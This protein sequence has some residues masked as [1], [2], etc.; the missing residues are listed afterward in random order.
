MHNDEELIIYSKKIHY[1]LNAIDNKFAILKEIE[2]LDSIATDNDSIPKWS[3]WESSSGDYVYG[4]TKMAS[5]TRN[6]KSNPRNSKL[7]SLIEEA[8]ILKSNHYKQFNNIEL[9]GMTPFSISKYDNG[10]SMGKHYDR[11]N[12][13][14]ISAILY[15][16]DDYEGGELLFPDYN[17]EIKPM[18]GS[19]VIFPSSKNFIH[20]TKE[21]CGNNRYIAMCFWSK[22]N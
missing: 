20:Y 19:M 2:Y 13:G 1:Y 5:P 8:F 17:V 10:K 15:L 16:N 14:T 7:H 21:A 6:K 11:R 9:G 22:D 3:V 12:N 4:K 18:A